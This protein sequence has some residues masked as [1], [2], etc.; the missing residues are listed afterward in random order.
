MLSGA[1]RN[2][3]IGVGG[4]GGQVPIIRLAESSILHGVLNASIRVAK[5]LP[6]ELEA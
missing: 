2:L 3:F 6:T 5:T 1:S 4:G